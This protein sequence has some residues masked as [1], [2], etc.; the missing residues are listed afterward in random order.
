MNRDFG[1]D[2]GDM[3]RAY[4]GESEPEP[5]VRRPKETAEQKLSRENVELV[6]ALEEIHHALQKGVP[7]V[8]EKVAYDAIAKWG[9][10]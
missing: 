3:A 2:H 10:G 1:G 9:R 7:A 5:I 8:A 4:Y 6:N